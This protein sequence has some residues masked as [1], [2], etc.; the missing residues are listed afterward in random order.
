M[1]CTAATAAGCLVTCLQSAATA[2]T[3]CPNTPTAVTTTYTCATGAAALAN[4]TSGAAFVATGALPATS[5]GA[6]L[7]TNCSYGLYMTATPF[8]VTC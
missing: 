8:T 4:T 5:P 6:L 7:P 2:G 3:F 1:A